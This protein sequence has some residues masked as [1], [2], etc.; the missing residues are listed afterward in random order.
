MLCEPFFAVCDQVALKRATVPRRDILF[1][2][3]CD[4]VKDLDPFL[5]RD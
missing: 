1:L 4:K 2:I 3:Q 5:L